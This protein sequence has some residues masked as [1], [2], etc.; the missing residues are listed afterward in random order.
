MFLGMLL[1]PSALMSI[2]RPLS[3]GKGKVG[4]SKTM[5]QVKKNSKKDEEK[6]PG[7]AAMM[8]ILTG[9]VSKKKV[10]A[11]RKKAAK[12]TKNSRK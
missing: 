4:M 12:A 3:E 11:A 9:K 5:K 8:K 6:K 2:S 10:L 7:Q 1:V